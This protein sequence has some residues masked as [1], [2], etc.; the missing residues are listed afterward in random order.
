MR[1]IVQHT[2]YMIALLS[3]LTASEAQFE[4]VDRSWSDRI[5]YQGIAVEESEYHVRGASPVIGPEGKTHLFVSRWPISTTFGGWFEHSEIAR[6]VGDTP[7]GPFV[8][9]EVILTGTNNRTWDNQAPHNPHVQ[10][11]GDQYV[12][13]YMASRGGKRSSRLVS[14]S[15]GMMTAD[16]PAGPWKKIG[17]DG[18][19]LSSPD[20]P[21]I[22]SY[23]STVGITNPSLFA[24][25]DGRFFL[26]YKA[27]RGTELRRIGVA[28]ADEFEGPYVFYP[29]PLTSNTTKIEDA[30]V[31][32]ENKRVKLIT[33]DY[34]AGAGY[35][36]ESNNGIRFDE[37]KLGFETL[38]QYI[39]AD[40][41]EK[42]FKLKTRVER[43]DRPQLLIQDGRPTYLYAASSSNFNGGKG[44]YSCV[45]KILPEG[46]KKAESHE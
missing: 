37:P 25:P 3:T 29:E 44:S 20:E 19:L 43:L 21:V 12:L 46:V 24:H 41:L 1:K 33:T 11:I 2:A 30:Y 14:Q 45:F 4:S 23:K 16:H 10:K 40:L 32:I 38:D 31:F 18:L 36:W 34:E 17:E 15:I 8:F 22:W 26:Y 39:S 9:K 42:S 13:V 35:L 27:R 5:E 28:I 6:Y 7:E